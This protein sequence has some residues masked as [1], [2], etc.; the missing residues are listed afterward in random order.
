MLGVVGSVAMQADPFVSGG[1]CPTATLA[2]YAASSGACSFG[3]GNFS[4]FTVS[5]SISASSILVTPTTGLGTGLSAGLLSGFVFTGTDGT[6]YSSTMGAST[7]SFGYLLMVDPRVRVN[8]AEFGITSQGA[9]GTDFFI[10]THPAIVGQSPLNYFADADSTNPTTGRA[11]E[12]SAAAPFGDL[13]VGYLPGAYPTAYSFT[14]LLRTFPTDHA[15]QIS[16]I[17]QGYLL[18]A[19]TPVPEPS[20]CLLLG[21]GLIG[22]AWKRRA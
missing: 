3:G 13:T 17:D 18:P 15:F 8:V 11:R 6:L 19:V 9:S 12:T 10:E 2:D 5:G 20:T 22:L 16:S 1:I 4:G 21:A 7:L 14:T